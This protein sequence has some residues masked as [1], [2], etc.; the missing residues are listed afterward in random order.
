MSHEMYENDHAL[1]VGKP[2]W[3]GLG[4]VI[5]NAPTTMDAMRLAKMDFGVELSEPLVAAFGR[6]EW[7]TRTTNPSKFHATVR[8]DTNEVL[9]VVNKNYQIVQNEELFE[10]ADGL[11]N[12]EVETA[13]TLYN[14][15]QSYILMKDD[16]WA[17]N[18]NDEMHEYLCLM[19]SHNGSL[20][21]SAVPP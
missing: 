8:T 19:N 20:S 15:A 7:G 9:G 4:T 13:G 17:V 1:Y 12:A 14:G 2:A 11:G 21:L 6:D 16:E 18:G 10:I 5:E 3:H